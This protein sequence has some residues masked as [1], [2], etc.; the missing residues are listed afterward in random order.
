M[1]WS[2]EHPAGH[3]LGRNGVVRIFFDG[4]EA[5]AGWTKRRWCEETHAN[6]LLAAPPARAVCGGIG[7]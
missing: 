5:I 1:Q 2:C 6:A 4:F 7:W 3:T